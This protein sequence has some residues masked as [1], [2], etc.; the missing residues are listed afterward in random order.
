M[1]MSRRH[2]EVA[3]ERIKVSVLLDRLDKHSEGKIEMTT[4]QVK[5]TEILL[6]RSLPK[7]QHIQ[8]VGENGGPIQVVMAVTDRNAL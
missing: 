1:P 6:D 7:L 5:A 2:T 8:H 4:T 3:R